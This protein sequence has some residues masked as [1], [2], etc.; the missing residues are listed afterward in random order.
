MRKMTISI[1]PNALVWKQYKAIFD[2]IE[3]IEL[4]ELMKMDFTN[5]IKIVLVDMYTKPGIEL[6]KVKLPKKVE[7]LNILDRKGDKY[8]CLMKVTIPKMFHK[9]LNLFNFE[10]IYDIPTVLRRKRF[11]YSM[12]GS[13]KNLRRYLKLA[14][15]MGTVEKTIFKKADY[16]G[17]GILNSLTTKQEKILSEAVK[18]G[19]YKYPRQIDTTE[20]ARRIGVS[21][22]TLIEHL[23]KAENRV[24]DKIVVNS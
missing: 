19:Y 2:Q 1:T 16:K 11:V 9:L 18:W 7:I 24:M 20:L 8:T 23:R 10:M 12:I 4:Q 21:K 14:S 3:R 13:E 5:G 6:A 22:T 15:L 17:H